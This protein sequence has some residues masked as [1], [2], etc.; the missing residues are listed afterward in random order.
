MTAADAALVGFDEMFDADLRF[1]AW[2]AAYLTPLDHRARAEIAQSARRVASLTALLPFG[3]LDMVLAL[4]INLRMIRRLADMYG[5]RTGSFGAWRLLRS[6]IAQ[7]WRLRCAGV[8]DDQSAPPW[9]VRSLRNFRA[10][11]GEGGC[12]TGR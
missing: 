12:S 7:L 2:K 3:I 10:R 1:A 8:G 11:F 9:A 5:G 6:V 4:W